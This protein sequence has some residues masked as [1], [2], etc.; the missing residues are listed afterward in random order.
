MKKPLLNLPNRGRSTL[1]YPRHMSLYVDIPVQ[2]V[3]RKSPPS[4]IASRMM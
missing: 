3:I 4:T 1:K 2:S